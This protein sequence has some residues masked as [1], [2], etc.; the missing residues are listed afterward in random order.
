LVLDVVAPTLVTIEGVTIDVVAP[1]PI[2]IKGVHW[3]RDGP[4]L[5]A[6]LMGAV[7]HTQPSTIWY[8]ICEHTTM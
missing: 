8:D 7:H 6:V 1:P 2:T 5:F 4:N 3:A